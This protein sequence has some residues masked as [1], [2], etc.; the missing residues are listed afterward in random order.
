M[1][2][3]RT[4]VVFVKE[5][6]QEKLFLFIILRNNEIARSFQNLEQKLKWN[7]KLRSRQT[8]AKRSAA[9]LLEKRK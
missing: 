8:K 1:T 2:K 3:N 5:K 4:H 7:L 9:E 6:E